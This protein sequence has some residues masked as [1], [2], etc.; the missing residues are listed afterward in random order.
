MGLVQ[1]PFTRLVVSSYDV[2]KDK[3]EDMCNRGRKG[4]N[5]GTFLP[6]C[7]LVFLKMIVPTISMNWYDLPELT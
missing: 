2:T 3:V 1:L 6:H 5:N 4:E 7:W